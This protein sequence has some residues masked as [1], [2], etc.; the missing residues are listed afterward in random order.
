M[1]ALIFGAGGQLGRALVAAAPATARV[2]ALGR[3]DCDI[4]DRVAVTRAIDG[5][6]P[7]LVFNAAAY[8]DVDKAEGER[9]PARTVNGL[10]PGWMAGA[11]RAIGSRFVH[12]ST[13]F[14][15]D[16]RSP[17][18]L[19]PADPIAPLSVY[20]RTKAE[21]ER[22]VASADP[23]ALIVRTAWLYAAAGANFVDTIVR[24]MSERDEIRVVAD[25][26]GT[27]TWARSLAAA[28][29]A[30]A[31]QGARGIHHFTDAGVASRYDFA[32]AIQEEALALGLIDRAA[33]IVPIAT[34][35]YPRPA[36]RPAFCVLDKSAT[37]A[38][39][40]GPAPHWRS[41]LRACLREHRRG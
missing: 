22:A 5:H 16:G 4:S 28:L 32:I 10:A 40:G 12:L 36:Q 33:R 14:V 41:N 38:L 37:W 34:V 27:P 35:D 23:E 9:E 3:I 15:F 2:V 29:W 26:V 31:A 13:D 20:G 17:R 25:Q 21:G 30:L 7:E 18:P 8:T 24:L 39:L 1:K 19:A 11:V 6:R